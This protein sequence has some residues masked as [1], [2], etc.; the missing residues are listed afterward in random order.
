MQVRKFEARSMKEAL[1]MVKTQM[2]PDAIILSAR[3]HSKKYGLVGAGS[4]EITAAVHASKLQIKQAVESRMRPEDR[5]RFQSS[6]AKVQK[7]ALALAAE[8]ANQRTQRSSAKATAEAKDAAKLLGPR[9]YI[10]IVD[11][12]GDL[13]MTAA[14]DL[15]VK[16]AAK[17][18]WNALRAQ[19]EWNAEAEAAVQSIPRKENSATDAELSDVLR[20]RDEELSRLRQEL[21][22]LRAK[23]QAHPGSEFGLPLEASRYFTHLL[24]RGVE[25][26]L[27]ASY[28]Q[29]AVKLGEEGGKS[30]V[31]DPFDQRVRRT[32][33]AQIA[34]ADPSQAPRTQFFVGPPG[35]GKTSCLIKLAA[36]SILQ[37]GQSVAILTADHHKV[38]AIDQLKTY[39]SILN[40]PFVVVRQAA[41]FEYVRQ[42]LPNYDR[43]LCDLPGFSLGNLDELSYLQ[44]IIP[45]DNSEQSVHLVLSAQAR[46]ESLLDITRRY[47]SLQFH[48]VIFNGLDLCQRLGNLLNWLSRFRA[49]VF[50]VGT[51]AHLPDD[52]A[53]PNATQL[54]DWIL[55]NPTHEE[56]Q[57]EKSL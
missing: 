30:A 6:S 14:G 29:L 5:A 21:E 26:E 34:V 31:R 44:K 37:R 53:F 23:S 50:A 51:G 46:N 1:Q 15:R 22:I 25:T 41:D 17:A 27:A 52:I 12:E 39:A 18:A 54:M 49:P 13:P 7:E 24:E 38:G 9:R 40:V 20:S 4:V 35:S 48:D 36:K 8:R 19:G 56:Q 32:I 57:Q 42:Q 28:L 11:E 16:E 33:E 2:G 55:T 45:K 47:R 3:D 43:F 10:D